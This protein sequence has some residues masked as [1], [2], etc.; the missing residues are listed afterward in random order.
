MARLVVHN[1]ARLNVVNTPLLDELAAHLKVLDGE[2]GLQAVVLRGGGERA[3][4]GGADVYEMV[5]LDPESARAF[6]SR[7]HGVCQALRHLPVPVVARI[8]GYCLGAGLEMAASCDL[9]VASQDA[10]FGMPEVQVGIP[11]VIEAALLP[12]LVGW[13]RTRQ[14]VF[15]GQRISAAQALEWG[16]VERVVPLPELDRAEEEWLDALVAAGPR[17]LRAQKALLHQ[18][19]RLPLAEAIEAGVEAFAAAYE[20]GEP[21]E[22]MR[23][24]LDRPRE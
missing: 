15:T 18:W 5:D 9:R 14:L 10:Q 1:P 21:R 2:E 13:G 7:L 11:S 19:E 23:R 20:T 4:I 24:F 6:I 12:G 8:Q 3:F 17:A 16:L 22:W